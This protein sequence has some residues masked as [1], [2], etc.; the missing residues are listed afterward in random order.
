MKFPEFSKISPQ[1]S[2]ALRQKIEDQGIDLNDI[3][4]SFTTGGGKG[5]QKVNKT[6]NCVRLK[7]LPTGIS[8]TCQK[9][10]ER[11]LNRFLALRELI[12]KLSPGKS[13]KEIQSERIRKQKKRKSRKIRQKDSN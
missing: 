7:H 3:E 4:E 11:S 1:K 8:V 12:E 6:A 10:R 2:E 13:R 9:E 5:G